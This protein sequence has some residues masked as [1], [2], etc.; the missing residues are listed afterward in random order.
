MVSDHRVRTGNTGEIPG[1]PRRCESPW[2]FGSV[3]RGHRGRSN[4]RLSPLSIEA[5]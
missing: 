3:A 5:F 2:A 4:A 1:R